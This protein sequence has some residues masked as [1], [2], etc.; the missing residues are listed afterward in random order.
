MNKALIAVLATLGVF[1]SE[2][3]EDS[4]FTAVLAK[5]L[6]Y[7]KTK[8]YDIVYPAF[9]GR[10]LVPVNNE[11]P[12]GAKTMA[13]IQWDSFGIANIIANYADDIELVDVLAEEFTIKLHGIGKGYSYSI[14]DLRASAMANT[15][16]ETKKAAATRRAVEQKIENMSAIGDSVVGATG[17]ANNAN[18]TLITP[19][20]GTWSGA[21]GAQQ[22]ADMLK[23]ERSIISTNKET[24]LPTTLV[25]DMTS[26]GL[27][28][29]TRISTTGDTHTTAKQAF[30]ASAQ[31]VTEVVAW[32]KVALADAA[33]TGPRAIMYDKNPDVLELIIPQ[34]YEQFPPQPKNYSFMIPAHAKC[35]GVVMYYPIAVGY[36]DGL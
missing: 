11:V 30:L 26:Y 32:D 10:M 20:T 27:F 28:N 15:R 7:V 4:K 21:T 3:R 35:G 8:T 1:N 24:F 9:K 18:V 2:F 17:L 36:M 12:S 25:L 5:Q 34:E 33:G 19:I 16:L 23:F 14:D 13:Y 31:S 6:E 29:S 22:V